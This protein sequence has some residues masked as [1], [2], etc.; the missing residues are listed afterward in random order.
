[1]LKDHTYQFLEK[2]KNKFV[3]SKISLC[4]RPGKQVY[5]DCKNGV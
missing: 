5:I 1:M 2:D 4:N 3:V